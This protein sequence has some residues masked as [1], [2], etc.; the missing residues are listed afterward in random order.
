MKKFI[1]IVISLGAVLLFPKTVWITIALL[2]GWVTPLAPLSAGFLAEA[3]YGAP[4]AFPFPLY[5]FSGTGFALL[6][7]FVRR[8]IETRII[9]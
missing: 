8:F 6:V 5:A 2:S 9:R 1:F 7:F 3:L 4:E